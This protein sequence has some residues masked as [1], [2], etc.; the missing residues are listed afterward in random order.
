MTRLLSFNIIARA[1]SVAQCL[2]FLLV[3]EKPRAR[4]QADPD[5]ICGYS[6]Y[7]LS[8]NS[9]DHLNSLPSTTYHPSCNLGFSRNSRF[10]LEAVP[11]NEFNERLVIKPKAELGLSSIRLTWS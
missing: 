10:S 6:F 2:A 5:K 7:G 4:S 1:P 8:Y 3:T 9:C 11:S